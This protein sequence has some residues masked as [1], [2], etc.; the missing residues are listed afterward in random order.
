MS[1]P[2]QSNGGERGQVD[3]QQLKINKGAAGWQQLQS[4]VAAAAEGST[5]AT[6][7]VRKPQVPN[8]STTTFSNSRSCIISIRCNCQLQLQSHL[9]CPT[10][11]I[12]C[13]H[14]HLLLHMLSEDE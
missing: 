8:N 13:H 5:S 11:L 1:H 12:C 6:V 9:L 10:L 4:A 2:Y 3:Q 7:G 14:H